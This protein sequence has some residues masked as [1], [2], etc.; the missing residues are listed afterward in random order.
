MLGNV[1]EWV[2]DCWHNNYDDAPKDGSAWEEANGGDCARRVV[3]GGCWF[4]GTGSVRSAYRFRFAPRY[5]L[6]YI[7]FRLAQDN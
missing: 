1:W 4:I 3:R 5:R 2:Q 6:N 7:G